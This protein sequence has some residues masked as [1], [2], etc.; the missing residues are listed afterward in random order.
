[1]P[2]NTPDFDCWLDGF[3][4]S[5]YRHRPVNATFIGRHDH[6]TRLP[7]YSEPG[8][9]DNLADMQSVLQRA[10][11]LAHEPLSLAQ[12]TDK[13]LCEG[14]LQ[15][16]T[17]EYEGNHGLRGNPGLYIGEAIFGVLAA[18][19]SDYAPLADRVAVATERLHA[20]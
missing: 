6:D 8:I 18:F 9:A 13:R 12:R 3:F 17:W 5:Y 10:K 19:L 11:N 16:Q 1:M 15:I 20:P 2:G 14:F 4:D 7:D